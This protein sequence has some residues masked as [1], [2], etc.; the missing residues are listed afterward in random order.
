[1]NAG[2]HDFIDGFQGKLNSIGDAVQEMFFEVQM[3]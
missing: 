1:M 2:L 3:A